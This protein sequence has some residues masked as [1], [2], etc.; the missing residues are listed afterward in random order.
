M[1]TLRLICL[2]AYLALCSLSHTHGGIVVSFGPA[3]GPGLPPFPPFPLPPIGMPIGPGV[4]GDSSFPS[5]T[6]YT[7]ALIH[8]AGGF[9]WLFNLLKVETRKSKV[10]LVWGLLAAFYKLKKKKLH[11]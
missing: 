6:S 10:S 1:A 2:I 11:V 9:P 4:P 3:Q 7:G 8:P 5:K